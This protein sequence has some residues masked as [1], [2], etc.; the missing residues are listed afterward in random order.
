MSASPTKSFAEFWPVYVAAHSQPLTR[1]FHF[2]GT[3]LGWG[4]LA[5]AILLRKPWLL[6]PA[7]ISGYA[8]AWIS[9]FFVEHNR[10]ATFGHPLWSWVA[11]Q[12]MVAF[13]L[14][15]RMGAE[16]RRCSNSG[17]N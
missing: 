4:L 5:S 10:P 13:M 6:L 8:F 7:L 16:V 15:G 1:T 11:D 3:L 2:C 12:K 14:T 9:H 17:Q